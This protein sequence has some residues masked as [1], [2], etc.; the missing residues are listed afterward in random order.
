[1]LQ[2]LLKKHTKRLEKNPRNLYQLILN[3][4]YGESCSKFYDGRAKNK[5]LIN[6]KI[7]P[8]HAK[9]YLMAATAVLIYHISRLDHDFHNI[10]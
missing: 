3:P 5:K 10:I 8:A 4:D 2:K 7:E 1:M 9:M 6:K